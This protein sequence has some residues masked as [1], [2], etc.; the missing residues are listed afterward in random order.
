V[1]S[2]KVANE[3]WEERLKESENARTAHSEDILKE[4]ARA[5]LG[6]KAQEK[7]KK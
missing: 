5:A 6:I 3:F 7:V 1:Y 4:M 2:G